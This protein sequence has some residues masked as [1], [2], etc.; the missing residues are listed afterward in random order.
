VASPSSSL[1]AQGPGEYTYG[2]DAAFWSPDWQW[3]A[4]DDGRILVITPQNAVTRVLVTPVDTGFSGAGFARF[5]V[6][7]QDLLPAA[8]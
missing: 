4:A 1:S 5:A 3:V 8:G 7:A 2:P 6:T